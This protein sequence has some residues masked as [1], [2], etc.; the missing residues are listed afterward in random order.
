MS[1]YYD[2]PMTWINCEEFAPPKP[3][4]ICNPILRLATMYSENDL[5]PISAL[6]HLIFCERQCALI[7]IE[8]LW[9]ENRLTVEGKHLHDKAHEAGGETRHDVRI[10]RAVP[11]VSYQLGLTGVADVVEFHHTNPPPDD[12]QPR[13]ADEPPSHCEYILPIEYKRGKPKRDGSD[14]V[15]LTAQ[16]IALEEMLNT[17]IERGAIFYGKTRR[18]IDVPFDEPLRLLTQQT[19]SRLHEMIQSGHTPSAEYQPKCKRCSLLNLCLPNVTGRA[20]V[21]RWFERSLQ[22]ML[23]SPSLDEIDE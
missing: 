7:H 11:L 12:E 16:A 13:N 21:N 14:R 8:Q 3:C 22:R 18:R 2:Y 20:S 6:Q 4:F 10:A 17:P 23:T 15:Q 19:A 1:N 5:L 9:A